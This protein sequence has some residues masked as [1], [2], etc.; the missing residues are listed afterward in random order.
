VV[1]DLGEVGDVTTGLQNLCCETERVE[2]GSLGS[3]EM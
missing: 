2:E 3:I 1:I